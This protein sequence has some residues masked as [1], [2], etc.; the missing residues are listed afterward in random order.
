MSSLLYLCLCTGVI[1]YGESLLYLC[2]CT[3]VI[4]YGES[5]LYLC[6]CTGVIKYGETHL[7][8]CLCTGVIKYV[9]NLLYLCLCTGVIK[10]GESLLIVGGEDDKSWM[11]GMCW[12]RQDKDRL[13]WSEGIELPTVMST[14][15]CVVANMPKD[16][17][18]S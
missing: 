15:G 1:K 4:K 8:L 2:L 12:L 18:S 14:F 11:A 17:M 6:L 7:Y 10:Y 5:H 3:G 9:K 16:L 13:Y